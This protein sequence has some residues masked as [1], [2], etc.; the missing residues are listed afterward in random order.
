MCSQPLGGALHQH[1]AA[2]AGRKRPVLFA[3]RALH[4]G[5]HIILRVD[6]DELLL[7]SRTPP[8]RDAE[9]IQARL[10]RLVFHV[11][12]AVHPPRI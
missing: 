1:C 3:I 2:E 5:Y 7:P 12:C 9:N 10:L 8:R 6:A 4:F 11:K